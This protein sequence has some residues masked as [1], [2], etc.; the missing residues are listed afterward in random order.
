MKLT[1]VYIEIN[2][3]VKSNGFHSLITQKMKILKLSQVFITRTYI[4]DLN[5]NKYI[6]N[7][8][9]TLK[10]YRCDFEKDIYNLAEKIFTN[11]NI[12]YCIWNYKS[13]IMI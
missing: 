7:S 11:I 9:I 3:D 12:K 6:N 13:S 8:I 5:P 10:N 2:N 1:Y 4:K